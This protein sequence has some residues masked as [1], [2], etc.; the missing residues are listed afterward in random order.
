[1][2]LITLMERLEPIIESE[3][4][5]QGLTTLLVYLLLNP[6]ATL[7][8]TLSNKVTITDGNV[9]VLVNKTIERA[10]KYKLEYE[11]FASALMDL[12]AQKERN[13]ETAIGHGLYEWD[14]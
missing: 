14:V 3:D 12:A 7:T 5:A 11:V 1:M 2:R 9:L 6:S 8:D 4:K 13:I 10:A